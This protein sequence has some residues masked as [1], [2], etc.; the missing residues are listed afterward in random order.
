MSLKACNLGDEINIIYDAR[1]YQRKHVYQGGGHDKDIKTSIHPASV[2]QYIF[3][4][5]M[6]FK[7]FRGLLMIS[8]GKRLLF[9]IPPCLLT[10][11]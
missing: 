4:D 7:T 2:T 8:L 3:K 6:S 11:E 9:Q 1:Y 5:F 10:N